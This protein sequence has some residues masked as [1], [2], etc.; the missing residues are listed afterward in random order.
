MVT[1]RAPPTRRKRDA[2]HNVKR[3]WITVIDI[4]VR[5]A[6]L[7][8]NHASRDA[9]S[10]QTK[11]LDMEVKELRIVIRAEEV[12]NFMALAVFLAGSIAAVL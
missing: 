5:K 3:K 2:R 12:F 7:A 8:S 9:R 11:G 6:P 1:D 10:R 4:T